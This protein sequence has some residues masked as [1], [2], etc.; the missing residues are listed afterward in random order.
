MHQKTKRHKRRVK[1]E[2]MHFYPFHFPFGT[3]L[4]LT[5]HIR[6]MTWQERLQRFGDTFVQ[7]SIVCHACFNIRSTRMLS[8]STQDDQRKICSFAWGPFTFLEPREPILPS[9]TAMPPKAPP[10]QVRGRDGSVNGSNLATS[11]SDGQDIGAACSMAAATTRR[12]L[13]WT[14]KKGKK[15][16]CVTVCGMNNVCASYLAS[17]SVYSPWPLMGG[18]SAA[19]DGGGGRFS[20][21]RDGNVATWWRPSDVFVELSD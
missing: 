19:G 7:Y 2:P 15:V 10:A 13:R 12:F 11:G 16:A 14:G 18:V 21:Q 4:T 9:T 20:V 6:E 8:G 5:K 17:G 3:H 1:N